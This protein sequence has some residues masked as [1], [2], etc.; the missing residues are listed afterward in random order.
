MTVL[1]KHLGHTLAFA[2]LS[3]AVT[4]S[5]ALAARQTYTAPKFPVPASAR[6][7]PLTG[8]AVVS[9]TGAPT[10]KTTVPQTGATIPGATTPTV[11]TTTPAPATISVPKGRAGH[12]APKA[13]AGSG[14][15]STPAAIAAVIAALLALGCAIWAI[16]R[17]QAYEPRWT[18]SLRHTFAEASFRASAT[19]AEFGDWARLGR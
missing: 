14:G 7:Q 4:P 11:A 9:P 15:L 6:V 8:G 10:V 13:T 1:R 17:V 12:V 3:V 18:L 19:W 5:A 16:A 2:I